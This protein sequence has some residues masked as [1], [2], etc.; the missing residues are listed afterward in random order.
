M[1][2]FKVE[3]IKLGNHIKRK[4]GLDPQDQREGFID[5]EAIKEA[6]QLIKDMC[7][8]CSNSI[9]LILSSL[10]EKWA[11][12]KDIGHDS[13]VRQGLSEE[14]FTL[15]H[16]IKDV[17][18]MCGYELI[19]HFAESLRDYIDETNLNLEAQKVIIQAHVD[20]MQLAHKNDVKEDNGPLAN[21]LRQLVKV[22]IDK[23]K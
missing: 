5:P 14:I 6:D 11:M 3:I 20:A 7:A 9:G 2:R 18:A 16:E 12:M 13:S 1:S 19:A 22:A 21:E 10:S 4:M 23:Y 8:E 17:G 15:S